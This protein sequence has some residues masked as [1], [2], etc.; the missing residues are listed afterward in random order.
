MA[1]KGLGG[2]SKGGGSKG[3]TA[4]ASLANLL[5]ERTE[6]EKGGERSRRAAEEEQ[7]REMERQQKRRER[8]VY[9]YHDDGG[10][11]NQ[12][13]VMAVSKH[14]RKKN[15]SLGYYDGV[16]AY[17]SAWY[18]RVQ[19]AAVLRQMIAELPTMPDPEREWRVW[20]VKEVVKKAARFVM[21]SAVVVSGVRL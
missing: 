9:Y 4:A 6:E 10:A 21:M 13:G 1:R 17:S 3:G 11:A 12:L 19:E 20:K 16:D 2:G 14:W 18:G 5:R 15:R 7:K 8:L